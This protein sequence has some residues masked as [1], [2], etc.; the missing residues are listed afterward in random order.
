MELHTMENFVYFLTCQIFDLMIKELSFINFDQLVSQT[1]IEFPSLFIT[2]ANFK[3]AFCPRISSYNIYISSLYMPAAKY[4]V[5]IIRRK[6]SNK[7]L[8]LKPQRKQTFCTAKFRFRINYTII[9]P[10]MQFKRLSCDAN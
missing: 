2:K 3:S 9:C 10:W 4:F 7:N 8:N 1:L 5:I 6:P